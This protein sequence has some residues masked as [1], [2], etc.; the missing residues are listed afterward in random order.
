MIYKNG[1]EDRVR[2]TSGTYTGDNT[3]DRAIAH[4]LRRVPKIVF[5]YCDT[6]GHVLFRRMA[7]ASTIIIY[8]TSAAQGSE[9]VAAND[10]TNYYVG[11]AASYA[12]SAN[13]D[14]ERY[15]WVAIG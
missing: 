15:R 8:W 10:T 14:G 6:S 3:A 12:N 4:G 11:D 9:A 5:I 2:T 1:V 7:T 13:A